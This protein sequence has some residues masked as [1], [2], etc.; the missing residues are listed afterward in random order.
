MWLTNLRNVT[1]ARRK[2]LEIEMKEHKDNKQ[3]AKAGGRVKQDDVRIGLEEAL[4][5][6]PKYGDKPPTA[7]VLFEVRT[8]CLL[9]VI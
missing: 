7:D 1:V 4:E 6:L 9:L 2:Q 8:C 3:K 5:K